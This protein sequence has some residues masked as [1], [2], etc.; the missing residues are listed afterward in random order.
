MVKRYYADLETDMIEA[1]NYLEVKTCASITD[2]EEFFTEDLS[3]FVTYIISKFRQRERPIFYFHN[4]QFDFAFL[5]KEMI[6]NQLEGI[7]SEYI[8]R[9]SNLLVVKFFVN[10]K[11]HDKR[12]NRKAFLAKA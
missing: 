11:S 3:E 10:H 7:T 5:F 2:D 9:G 1:G 12:K 6:M 8:I 4:L